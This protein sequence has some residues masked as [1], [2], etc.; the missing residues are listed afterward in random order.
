[1]RVTETKITETKIT[2]IKITEEEFTK[3]GV[4]ALISEILGFCIF[5]SIFRPAL[6]IIEVFKV[7]KTL[8]SDT[9]F[10]GSVFQAE[11]YY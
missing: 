5:L 3:L 9:L 6:F 4:Y 2:E 10:K 8:I 1:M 11:C 7:V